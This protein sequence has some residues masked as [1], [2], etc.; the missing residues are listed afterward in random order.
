MI[1]IVRGFFP[2]KAPRAKKLSA[3]QM[4]FLEKLGA[5]VTGSGANIVRVNNHVDFTFT[6]KLPL[7]SAQKDEIFITRFESLVRGQGY[8]KTSFKKVCD[9]AQEQ[10]MDVHVHFDQL[11]LKGDETLNL[12]RF[13]RFLTQELNFE[14]GSV[15]TDHHELFVFMPERVRPKSWVHKLY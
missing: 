10:Q 3:Q 5:R 4:H 14:A 8:L 1:E 6:N 7:F 13:A 12:D 2:G 15:S 9:V 11:E